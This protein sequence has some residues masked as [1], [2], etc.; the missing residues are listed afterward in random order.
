MHK[1]ILA[2]ERSSIHL[3]FFVSVYREVYPI[4]A[5]VGLGFEF[6]WSCK[7]VDGVGICSLN[8]VLTLVG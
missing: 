1:F 5:L 7:V 6:N 3:F 4:R 8:L 2:Y